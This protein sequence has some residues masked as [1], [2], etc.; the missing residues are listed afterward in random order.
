MNLIFNTIVVL[1]NYILFLFCNKKIFI[2]EK[3][4]YKYFIIFYF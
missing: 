3:G 2:N 1:K 4:Y